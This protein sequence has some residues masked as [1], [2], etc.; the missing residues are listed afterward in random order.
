M[1]G[2]DDK[3]KDFVMPFGKHRGSTLE[4]IYVYDKGYLDWCLENLESDDI[5]EKIEECFEEMRF[6][7]IA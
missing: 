3:S 2:S 7:T 1:K 6:V 4:E 5:I